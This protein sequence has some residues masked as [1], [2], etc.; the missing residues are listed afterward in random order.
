[1]TRAEHVGEA[2]HEI[3][4]AEKNDGPFGIAETRAFDQERERGEESGGETE[5]RP[6]EH[7]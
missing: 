3:A 6:D 4:G 1:M 2:D 7:P 5:H